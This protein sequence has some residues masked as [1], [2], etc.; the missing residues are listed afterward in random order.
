M[1][2]RLRRRRRRYRTAAPRCT[3]PRGRRWRRPRRRSR[4]S[5]VAAARSASESEK[6]ADA[7]P[8]IANA[9][10][11]PAAPAAQPA[12]ARPRSGDCRPRSATPLQSIANAADRRPRPACGPARRRICRPR[13]RRSRERPRRSAWP[14]RHGTCSAPAAAAR[15]TMQPLLLRTSHQP[16][17]R[18]RSRRPVPPRSRR[19]R[20]PRRPSA[21]GAAF[22]RHP[23]TTSATWPA[24]HRRDLAV[25]L[26]DPPLVTRLRAARRAADRL[27]RPQPDVP[28]SH[29][30][31]RTSRAE[32]DA[33][34]GRRQ[35]LGRQPQRVEQAAPIGRRRGR[36]LVGV[37]HAPA[38]HAALS[39]P[40]ASGHST[41][42]SGGTTT[43]P[44]HSTR[45]AAPRPG[46]PSA[47]STVPRVRPDEPPSHQRRRPARRPD[48]PHTR[49]DVARAAGAVMPPAP[50][51]AGPASPRPAPAAR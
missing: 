25:A 34:R 8:K 6:P 12:A 4:P 23:R 9:P 21:D 50:G 11:A 28:S 38:D 31:C 2:T 32:A 37:R 42:R 5:R 18:P 17:A 7:A 39:V 33:G 47:R 49:H 26:A 13:R 44:S 1:Q 14:R 27:A 45:H 29:R 19:L 46:R 43:S 35:Q 10:A 3:S 41:S 40:K 15:T 16:T 22:A 30:S 20:R 24:P 51:A 36:P 48:G